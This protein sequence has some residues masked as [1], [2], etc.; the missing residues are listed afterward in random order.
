MYVNMSLPRAIS[1]LNSLTLKVGEIFEYQNNEINLIRSV[2]MRPVIYAC[3]ND[4][5]S[6]EVRSEKNRN[7]SAKIKART[8]IQWL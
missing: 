6:Q 5:G 3:E 1:N 7:E 4:L 2:F 8:D